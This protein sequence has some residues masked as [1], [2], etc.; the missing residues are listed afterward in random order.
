MSATKSILNDVAPAHRNI[1]GMNGGQIWPSCTQF[2]PKAITLKLFYCA[3]TVYSLYE[4]FIKS[5]LHFSI[6]VS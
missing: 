4:C 5:I 6:R 3:N 2:L 1:A